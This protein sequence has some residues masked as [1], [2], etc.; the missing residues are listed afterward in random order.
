M[1][2]ADFAEAAPKAP[3]P[4][5]VP[6]TLRHTVAVC[7]KR[8]KSSWVEL[9]KLLVQVRNDAMFEQWGYPS[10]EAYC[11]TELRIRKQTADKLVRSFSF[12]DRHEAPQVM[13]QPEVVES[14]PPFE[15]VEV[16][17]QAEERGQLS[18]QEY[19][20]IRDSIWNAERPVSELKRE[21]V[22]RFPAPEAELTDD[23]QLKRLVSLAKKLALELKGAKRVPKAVVERAEALVDDLAELTPPS[24]A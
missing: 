1:G 5:A 16:L 18:A 3:P 23:A 24:K 4:P 15:V 19:K 11:L 22:D 17:A 6:G 14:A 13:K 12:L 9:G 7:A 10:F 2:S 8:F 20:S 21:L